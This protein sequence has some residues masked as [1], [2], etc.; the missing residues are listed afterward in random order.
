ATLPDS[1]VRKVSVEN[2]I[3]DLHAAL[4]ELVANPSGFREMSVAARQHLK[5]M[6]A[7]SRYVSQFSD[8]MEDFRLLT[9]RFARRRMLSRVSA[10]AVS[11]AERTVL[12]TR[13]IDRITD[14]FSIDQAVADIPGGTEAL[15]F[16]TREPV[17]EVA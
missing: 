10:N 6:H 15:G 4:S 2:E 5:Q 16:E 9:E 8:A 14:L 1:I 11:P 12:L 13:A 17:G 3:L 7:P